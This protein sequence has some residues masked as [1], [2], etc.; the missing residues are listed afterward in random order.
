MPEKGNSAPRAPKGGRSAD[1]PLQQELTR[2]VSAAHTVRRIGHKQSRA[3]RRAKEGRA[4]AL[5]LEATVAELIAGGAPDAD[6]RAIGAAVVADIEAKLA[7]RAGPKV[8]D[9]GASH[10]ALQRAAHAVTVAQLRRRAERTTTRARE[11]VAA[12]AGLVDTA[13]AL[14]SVVLEEDEV[15]RMG[16]QQAFRF[17]GR[18]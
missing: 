8:R 13:R 7:R 2:L 6:I 1:S 5:R 18:A 17:A 4:I 15:A 10:E 3:M 14:S 16:G 9:E 12:A 11:V